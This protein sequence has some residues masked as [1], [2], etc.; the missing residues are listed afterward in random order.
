VPRRAAAPWLPR[1][2]AHRPTGASIG[3]VTARFVDT[4]RPMMLFMRAFSKFL[5]ED[6]RGR[7]ELFAPPHNLNRLMADL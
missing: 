4:V 7:H 1:A 3:P 2:A 5:A 6:H